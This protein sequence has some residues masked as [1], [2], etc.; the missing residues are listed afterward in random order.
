VEATKKG[1]GLKFIESESQEALPPPKKMQ[2]L[3]SYFI[4]YVKIAK[5][6]RISVFF[7]VEKPSNYVFEDN[8]TPHSPWGKS[9][10]VNKF[11]HYLPIVF[12]IGK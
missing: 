11:V 5:L 3:S 8:T 9:L 10:Q 7:I 6:R 1:G 12:L 4:G 2:N